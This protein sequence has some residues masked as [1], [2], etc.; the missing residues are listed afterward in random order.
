MLCPCRA[1]AL[2]RAPPPE[3]EHSAV[4]LHDGSLAPAVVR[5]VHN[6]PSVRGSIRIACVASIVAG[7][8]ACTGQIEEA[9]NVAG[10]PA[11]PV[12]PAEIPAI[13]ATGACVALGPADR[14]AAVSPEGDLWLDDGTALRVVRADGTERSVARPSGALDFLRATSDASAIAVADGE[15]WRIDGAAF[16]PAS[17]PDG[18]MGSARQVCGRAGASA[19]GFVAASGGLFEHDGARW[20]RWTT[21]DGT[22]IGPVDHLA[23]V[24]GACGDRVPRLWFLGDGRAVEVGYGESPTVRVAGGLSM[25]ETLVR[26]TAIGPAALAGGSLHVGEAFARVDFGSDVS[27][28]DAAGSALWAIA[29]GEVYRLRDGAWARLEEALP[30]GDLAISVHADATAAAWVSG[31]GVACHRAIDPSLH[32]RGVSPWAEVEPTIAITVAAPAGASGLDVLLDGAV[33][34]SLPPPSAATWSLDALSL[35]AAG[36]RELAFHATTTTG[37]ATRTL[38]V[39]VA[40]GGPDTPVDPPP[41]PSW[42]RDVR[43]LANARCVRCHGAETTRDLTTHA[44]WVERAA[45]IRDRVGRMTGATGAMPPTGQLG[46]SDLELIDRW[47]DEG[48]EP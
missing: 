26:D 1:V 47:I 39:R 14:V 10:A 21:G 42:E 34:A 25:V 27:A 11:P 33:V 19:P 31:E 41:G 45:L 5:A 36:W 29:G 46:A 16:A 7:S 32:V 8:A 48:M 17:Q 38:H 4:R 30:A 22:P 35:G 40:G 9:P 6:G 43:P 3:G 15:L 37:T 12:A 23:S 13:A 28:I 18:D 20:W 44:G 2:P 24:D